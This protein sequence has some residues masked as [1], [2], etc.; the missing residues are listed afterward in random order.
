MDI[1]T[2][3]CWMPG[4]SK[5]WIDEVMHHIMSLYKMGAFD[6]HDVE[7]FLG[8]FRKDFLWYLHEH[9]EYHQAE[10]IEKA[11]VARGD[12]WVRYR[13]PPSPT[14]QPRFRVSVGV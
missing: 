10:D 3:E 2:L 4:E 7:D 14:G 6:H 1:Y 9:P 8:V 13:L 11:I 12:K 5:Q